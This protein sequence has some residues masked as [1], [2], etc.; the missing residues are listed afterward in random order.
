MLQ[1]TRPTVLITGSNGFLGQAIARGPL[2]SY[3]VIGL[4]LDKPKQPLDGMEAIGVDLTSDTSVADA[5][6]QVRGMAG[7]RIAS[8]IHLAAYYDTSG[9]DNPKYDAVTVQGTRR[10][11]EAL[12]AFETGQFVFSSTMLVHAPSPDRGV[13]IDEESRSTRLGPIR[14]RRPR[15]RS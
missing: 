5:L 11:L 14:S 8:V 2:G 1:E 13:K 10:L 6:E 3:R 4:D 15:P 12:K 7:D 9:E